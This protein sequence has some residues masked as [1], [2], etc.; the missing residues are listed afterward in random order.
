[1][2]D[3]LSDHREAT[4]GLRIASARIDPNGTVDDISG[5]TLATLATRNSDNT[6]VLVTCMHS[7][8]GLTPVTKL[9]RNTRGGEEMYQRGR[10]ANNKLGE[11]PVW[12]EDE[13][14]WIPLKL[15]QDNP[16]KDY[17][18]NKGDVAYVEHTGP[19]GAS[20]KMHDHPVHTDRYIIAGVF[21]LDQVTAGMK[22]VLLGSSTGEHE[23]EVEDADTSLTMSGVTFPHVIKIRDPGTVTRGGDSGGP[24]LV[25]ARNGVYRLLGIN[26]G[27]HSYNYATPAEVVEKELKITFGKRAP[28]AR[29]SAPRGAAFGATVTLDGNGSSDPEGEALTYRWKQTFRDGIT[30]AQKAAETV[31]IQNAGQRLP[32][33]RPQA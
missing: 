2:P 16:S 23:L 3:T 9:F 13:P 11:I 24:I 14:A 15:D 1:M 19:K 27:G 30:A 28:T 33:S 4:A 22:V 18:G 20:F 7:M 25:K 26:I 31:Q 8:A 10:I 21:P 12:D 17:S 5:G 32:P 6:K 29:A